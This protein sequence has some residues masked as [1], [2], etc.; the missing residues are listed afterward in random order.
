MPRS[1]RTDKATGTLDRI[2]GRILEAIGNLTG[3]QSQ[4]A[5]GKAARGRGTFRSSRGKGKS[6][7]R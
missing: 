5:K 3:K 2:A 7:A 4:K 6:R 1:A